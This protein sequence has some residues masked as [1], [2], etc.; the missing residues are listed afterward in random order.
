MKFLDNAVT[1]RFSELLRKPADCV[2]VERIAC[3]NVDASLE[4]SKKIVASIW[5][6]IQDTLF[7][8]FSVRIHPDCEI[9]FRSRCHPVTRCDYSRK[10]NRGTM[11]RFVVD[12]RIKAQKEK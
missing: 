12:C 4:R 9:T 6:Q 11:Y 8:K 1:C 2:R 10:R 5:Q 3:I 7:R